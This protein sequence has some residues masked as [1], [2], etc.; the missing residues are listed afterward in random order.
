MQDVT[1]IVS[2]HLT[3]PPPRHP[4]EVSKAEARVH[5][6]LATSLCPVPYRMGLESNMG[7]YLI[8]QLLRAPQVGGSPSHGVVQGGAAAC[9]S[10][11]PLPSGVLDQG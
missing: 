8:L 6:R 1:G 3:P 7:I 5:V 11:G 10:Q 9:P 4:G 2:N